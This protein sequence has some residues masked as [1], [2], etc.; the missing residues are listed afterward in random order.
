MPLEWH[1]VLGVIPMSLKSLIE[2]VYMSEELQPLTN[3]L[4]VI[5]EERNIPVEY[6]LQRKALFIPNNDYIRYFIGNTDNGQFY[7][8]DGTCLWTHFFIFP[9]E[10]LTKE[11][12]GF[13]GWDAY[14]KYKVITGEAESL[15]MYK[16]SNFERNKYFFADIDLLRDKFDCN[17]IFVVDGLFDGLSLSYHGIPNISLLGSRFSQ[18]VLYFLRWYK[19]V[20]VISDND[21]AGLGLYRSLKRSLPNV[22]RVIQ[23]K[24]KDIEEYLREDKVKEGKITKQFYDILN[25]KY[26][27]SD[28][29]LTKP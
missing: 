12:V 9:V 22:H 23:S 14:N 24:C 20:Y 16:V 5:K 6:L 28:V 21:S 19:A 2:K 29:I 3:Y 15:P 1:L 27:N 13:C 25:K 8:I 7:N 10:D 18:E 17:V 26:H 4:S 11:I